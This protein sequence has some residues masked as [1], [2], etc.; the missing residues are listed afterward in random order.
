MFSPAG[1]TN[2]ESEVLSF[3]NGSSR[4]PRSF[5]EEDFLGVVAQKSICSS[6]PDYLTGYTGKL[7]S[8]RDTDVQDVSQIVPSLGYTGYYKGKID[9]KLGRINIHRTEISSPEAKF[10]Y[11]SSGSP[12]PMRSYSRSR[13]GNY[14][15]A[16]VESTSRGF[17]V[18]RLLA[19]IKNK[20]DF[21]YP[22]LAEK[23]IKVKSLFEHYDNSMDG[24]VSEYDFQMCLLQLNI[25]L[26]RGEFTALLSHFDEDSSGAILYREFI[27]AVCPNTYPH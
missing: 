14:S 22:T 7:R 26:P 1:I 21:K 16:V 13:E 8:M 9:G 2:T 5:S 4:L 12:D 23:V 18:D 20:L 27:N 24:T 11:G 3:E 17:S 6:H 15:N 10:G 19:A 25:V